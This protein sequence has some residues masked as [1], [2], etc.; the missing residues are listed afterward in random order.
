MI[1]ALSNA[2]YDLWLIGGSVGTMAD[3]GLLLEAMMGLRA[4]DSSA[5]LRWMC[6]PESVCRRCLVAATARDNGCNAVA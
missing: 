1:G 3:A 5:P 2:T 4:G 6:L